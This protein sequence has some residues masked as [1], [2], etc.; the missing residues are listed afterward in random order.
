MAID[1]EEMRRIYRLEKNTARLVELPTDFFEQLYV[2]IDVERKKYF[3][4]LRDL[5]ATRA[6]DFGNLK[7]LVEEWFVVREKK[8]LN[9]VLIS[10]QLGEKDMTRLAGEEKVLFNAL[11]DALLVHR[12]IAKKVLE[13][14]GGYT[15]V[16]PTLETTPRLENEDSS[17]RLGTNHSTSIQP[18]VEKTIPSS[19]EN[20]S[21]SPHHTTVSSDDD[22]SVPLEEV[23]LSSVSIR[24]L[25]E[26]PSFVGTDMKEYGPY[27]EGETVSLP[28]KIARLFITRKLGEPI[29]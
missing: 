11:Y 19:V 15:A 29:K 10:A 14:N 1:F 25:S 22:S 3:D 8:L 18:R 24:V 20:A 21:V 26:I 6:R 9:S 4:S 12:E 7:K 27:K 23:S 17:A 5:N 28:D 13:A 16:V 2:L